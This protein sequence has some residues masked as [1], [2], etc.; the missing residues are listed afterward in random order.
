M[1][2][3]PK[4]PSKPARTKVSAVAMLTAVALLLPA[5]GIAQVQITEQVC[6]T[7]DI[8]RTQAELSTL[9]NKQRRLVERAAR[10]LRRLAN[11]VGDLNLAKRNVTF[12][13][14]L[15]EQNTGL[16]FSLP[17]TIAIDCAPSAL[18]TSTDI[19]V[20]T[21]FYAD[22]A[23]EM[24]KLTS[25]LIKRLKRRGASARLLRRL[26][27]KNSYYSDISSIEATLLPSSHSSCVG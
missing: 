2:H 1:K 17:S 5:S 26:R 14:D 19:S 4:T 3:L 12:V 23:I 25:G 18:C 20:T 6:S 9:A 11:Q 7:Y 22:N 27:K 10:R 15:A 21:N 8:T 16:T 24:R 13:K